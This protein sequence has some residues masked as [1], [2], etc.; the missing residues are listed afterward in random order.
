MDQPLTQALLTA[1]GIEPTMVSRVVFDFEVGKP[2]RM[3]LE[4]FVDDAVLAVETAGF[5]VTVRTEGK[6][7]P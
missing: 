5:A 1:A 7:C 3:Y 6:T 2:A 4:M